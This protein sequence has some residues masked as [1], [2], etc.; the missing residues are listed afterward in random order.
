MLFNAQYQIQPTHKSNN[1][2]N[3][4]YHAHNTQT[5]RKQVEKD[6]L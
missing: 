3:S 2:D 5:A 4:K 1:C 6:L